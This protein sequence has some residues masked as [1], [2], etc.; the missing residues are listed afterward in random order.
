MIADTV[1]HYIGIPFVAHGRAFEGADCWGLVVL[2]H[3]SEHGITLPDYGDRY[4][5]MAD[6]E[7][8]AAAFDEHKDD[9]F[10][11]LSTGIA[12]AIAAGDCLLVF[13]RGAPLHV[14]L[15][16]GE[17]FMLHTTATIGHSMLERI[18]GRKYAHA[19]G[20]TYRHRQRA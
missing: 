19:I 10:M 3:Q 13:A 14:G 6:W 16:V 11:M 18:D 8:R 12:P 20:A 9:D 17:R 5:T 7:H 15:Y 1:K 2:W 4:E